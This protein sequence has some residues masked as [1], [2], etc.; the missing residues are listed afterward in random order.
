MFKHLIAL[1]MAVAL[2]ASAGLV[3]ADGGKGKGDGKNATVKLE[4]VV[5][6]K[7]TGARISI[8]A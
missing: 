8:D 1:A 2:V 7:G 4:G 6:P 3:H 5:T